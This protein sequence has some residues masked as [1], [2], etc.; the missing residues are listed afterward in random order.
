MTSDCAERSYILQKTMVNFW[1]EGHDQKQLKMMTKFMYLI[2]VLQQQIFFQW[3]P[4]GTSFDLLGNYVIKIKFNEAKVVEK[5][6]PHELFIMR[7]IP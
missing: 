6:F 3:Q 5:C 4:L 2:K 1:K 7:E